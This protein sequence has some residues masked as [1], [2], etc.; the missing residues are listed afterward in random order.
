MIAVATSMTSSR[1]STRWPISSKRS[2]SRAPAVPS[3]SA[4]I[5]AWQTTPLWISTA[6]IGI[7]LTTGTSRNS[8]RSRATDVA[9]S[10]DTIAFAS[11]SSISAAV[12]SAPG[13]MAR[14]TASEPR[15]R[16]RSESTASPPVSAASRAARPEPASEKSIASGPPSELA[17]PRAIAVAMFPAPAKP[18]LTLGSL[19]GPRQ[20]PAVRTREQKKKAR[21]IVAGKVF[22]RER[23]NRRAVR[24]F[25]TG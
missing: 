1:T 18:I 15:A 3:S 22:E 11:P 12:S 16:S 7:V 4:S 9:P 24:W 25:R 5:G 13:F 8:S 21:D 17:Q 6:T 2:S 19:V 20:T 10:T 23:S 14:T